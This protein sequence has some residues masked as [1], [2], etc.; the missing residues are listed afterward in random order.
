MRANAL[1]L[2]LLVLVLGIVSAGLLGCGDDS[3]DADASTGD[4]GDGDG[5]DGTG[6]RM[7]LPTVDGGDGDG[8]GDGDA[9]AGEGV[10]GAP[11]G[12][13]ADCT[14][15]LSCVVS[16]FNFGVCAR[17]CA[18]DTDCGTELCASYSGLQ[19]DAHC[20]NVIREE[21]AYCGVAETSNCSNT[22][23][24]DCLYLPNLPI[25]VCVHFCDS[26]S[27]DG[28]GGVSETPVTDGGVAIPACEGPQTCIANIVEEGTDGID[29]ICGTYV[30]RGEPCG[31][32]LGGFCKEEDLCGNANPE[33]PDS[34]DY[35]CFQDCSVAD[36]C[37]EGTCTPYRDIAYCL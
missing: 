33:D 6:G 20:I 9:G 35:R 7:P 11:C 12:T 21:F 1:A 18:G 27:S 28:D 2:G 14:S 16:G 37:D 30:N 25:G 13:A 26:G 31:I 32:Q 34:E 29:G 19:V 22:L 17:P 5:D 36:V 23:G 15:D 24:L 8:D 3:G 4:G 10:E